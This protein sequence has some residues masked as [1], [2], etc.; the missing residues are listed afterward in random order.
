MRRVTQREVAEAC[1]VT[2]MTVSLALRHHPSIPERTR[3]RILKEAKRLGYRRDP[4]LQALVAHRMG[5]ESPAYQGT[6][7][8]ITAWPK[9]DGWK[10]NLIYR[11]YGQG[12]RARAEEL[13]YRV[14]E[15]WLGDFNWD[16][17][18]CSR[19]MEARGIDGVALCPIPDGRKIGL[20]LESFCCVRLGYSVHEPAIPAVA[21]DLRAAVRI[22][23]Q[24]AREAGYRRI[25]L[26]DG[27]R[28]LH[29]LQGQRTAQFYYE[30]H[31]VAESER[32]PPVL[33]DFGAKSDLQ[34]YLEEQ[35]VEALIAVWPDCLRWIEESGLRVP[36]DIGYIQLGDYGLTGVSRVVET[37][38]LVGE[39]AMNLIDQRL[40][41]NQRGLVEPPLSII[42]EPQ[43]VEGG[44]LVPHG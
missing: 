8:W 22:A 12:L 37:P 31:Q 10:D 26:A 19:V 14:E 7:G 27:R 1:G 20:S 11:Q 16:A 30:T 32:V 9:R 34:R 18:N 4:A 3:E 28:D 41:H 42:L 44:T 5:L 17:T 39:Q 38:E 2:T 35:R 36:A 33:L 6:V 25:G 29:R 43:W 24:K 40:R 13:G 23:Y 21:A 15:L